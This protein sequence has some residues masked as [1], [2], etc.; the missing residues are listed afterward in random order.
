ML[1]QFIDSLDLS[2]VVN[3]IKVGGA[4]ALDAT[5]SIKITAETLHSTDG[6]HVPRLLLLHTKCI[7]GAYSY[8]CSMTWSVCWACMLSK[9]RKPDRDAVRSGVLCGP[10]KTC[11]RL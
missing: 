4:L 7:D 9:N 3:W 8:R 10:E 5:K 1:P 6:S 11:V 2:L